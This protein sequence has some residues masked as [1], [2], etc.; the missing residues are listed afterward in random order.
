MTQH[1]NAERCQRGAGVL[2]RN[3]FAAWTVACA[4]NACIAAYSAEPAEELL[5]P[6]GAPGAKGDQANDRP[7][8]IIYLPDQ[9]KATGAAVVVCP[10]GGYGHLAMG[11]EGNDIGIWLNSFG[12]AAFVCDYRHRGKGYG[13]PAPLQDAQRAMRTVRARCK[14]FHVD[15]GRIGIMGF[16]AGGHL[17]STAAT[18]FDAGDPNSGDPIERVSCRP[19]FAI[20]CYAV[21][22]FNEPYTHNGSQKNLLGEDAAAELVNS[23]SNEKQ[24]TS[25]TPPTFLWHTSEDTAVPPENSIVFY[26]ALRRAG[27][28]AE[29]HIFSRGRHGLGLAAD[30][31]GTSAWPNLCQNW[32]KTQGLLESK[33]SSR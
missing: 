26:T 19:D 18:H 17:A 11:H 27:V 30:T 1:R 13:H 32:L 3:L 9:A 29:L 5:W 28:P 22:A 2:A 31:P 6:G 21:I 15:A 7:K 33:S 8:L 12:V 25:N 23:L 24:V 16:S 10:G 14:D 20:L 4:A